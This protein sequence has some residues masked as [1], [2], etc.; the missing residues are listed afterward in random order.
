MNRVKLE[1]A[2]M[3]LAV[4]SLQTTTS[5]DAYYHIPLASLTLTEGVLP[6]NSAPIGWQRCC[7]SAVQISPGRKSRT[8]VVP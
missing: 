1:L 7:M 8:L 5:G 2:G 6:S 4:L 3:I